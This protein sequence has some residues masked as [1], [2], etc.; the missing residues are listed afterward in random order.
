MANNNS[1]Y[2]LFLKFIETY[3]P[4][5]YKGID[6]DDPLMTELDKMM[7]RNNQFIYVSD[8]VHS[9]ILFTSKR[10]TQMLGVDPTDFSLY[11]FFKN[12]HPDDTFRFGLARNKTYKLAN[13]LL[14][15]EKGSVLFSTNLK[16]SNALGKYSNLLGQLYLFYSTNPYKSV[17]LLKVH[18]IIDWFKL[19]KHG[20][21]Y[22]VGTDMLYFRYPD[23]ELLL[24]GVQFSNREFEIIRL[25]KEGLNSE[26]IG[27]NLYLSQYTVNAHRSNILKKSG[28]TSMFEVIYDLMDKG[29]L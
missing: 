3:A 18:T 27:Q 28:K 7:E 25:I 19:L 12:T 1:D 4:N 14:L 16:T 17:F 5:G 23:K 11:H 22:Y 2:N 9:K 29:M 6:P 24:T 8:L 10:T 20:Y 13:D 26:Q 21:H 15:A